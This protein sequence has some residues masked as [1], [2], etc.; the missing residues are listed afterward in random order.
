M[1]KE[2]GITEEQAL[3][4]L[5]LFYKEKAYNETSESNGDTPSDLSS[6]AS[7]PEISKREIFIPTIVQPVDRGNA[8]KTVALI[9][10]STMICCVNLKFAWEMKWPLQKLWRP[11]LARNTDGTNNAGSLI[12]YKI[13]LALQINSKRIEQDFFATR[14]EREKIVLGHPWLTVYNPRIDWI[15]GK[16]T[17]EQGASP[18]SSLEPTRS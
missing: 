11:T 18:C 6:R 17:L 3:E 12:R 1:W 5:G 10:S 8:T 9:D 15:T 4:L 14:L 2:N 16:V 13:C 7:T